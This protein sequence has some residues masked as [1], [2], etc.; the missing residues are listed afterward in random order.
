MT[1][2]AAE[3][4]TGQKI[5]GVGEASGMFPIDSQ[6]ENYGEIMLKKWN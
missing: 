6:T 1:E 2:Q 4:L 5:L 3:E